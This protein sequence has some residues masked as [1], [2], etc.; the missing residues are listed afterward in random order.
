MLTGT[1]LLAERLWWLSPKLV[2]NRLSLACVIVAFICG[3]TSAQVSFVQITDPHLYD[4]PPEANENKRALIACVMKIDKLIGTGADYKFAVVTGD[5]GIE[6]LVKPLVDRKKL[7]NTNQEELKRIDRAITLKITGAALEVAN[8]IGQSRVKVWLF[9]PGNNDLIAEDP[10]TVN[11]YRDFVVLLGQALPG[12]EVID[13]C[14]TDDPN[15][16]VYTPD[17]RFVFIG[18]NNASFKN[19][20]KAKHIAN[21]TKAAIIVATTDLSNL[22]RLPITPRTDE[23]LNYVQQVIDRVDRSKTQPAYIFY[24]IP[25]IDDPHPVLNSDINL[26]NDREL[27]SSDQYA[28]SS[29]FVD[30]RVRERWSEVVAKPNVRGLFAGHFH[31][32]RRDTY[33]NFH[34]MVTAGYPGASL[35]KL[36]VCPPIS[37]KRQ[38]DQGNQARGFQAV[39]IDGTGRVSVNAFWYHDTSG[40]FESQNEK[41]L[42][43]DENWR[44]LGVI[45]YGWGSIPSYL[46]FYLVFI[47]CLYAA[48][49]GLKRT[50][51][52]APFHVPSG[53]QLPFGEHTVANSL[54]DALV[55]IHER[56]KDGQ[57]DETH[58]PSG[59]MTP[60]LEG[61]KFTA[62]DR[63][64]VPN[65][66]A[67]E[68]KGL[69]HD[70]IISFARKVFGKEL[71]IS[72]DVVGDAN[73][74]CLLARN[75]K[76]R[77]SSN[78]N[79]ATIEGLRKAC[80][81]LALRM[82][83][84]IDTTLLSAYATLR[85]SDL[86]ELDRLEEGLE[87]MKETATLLPTNALIAYDLGVTH[88]KRGENDNAIAAF[89][90]A[91]KLD[92]DFPEA[93]NNLGVALT[94]LGKYDEAIASY[95][96]ALSKR[97]DYAA[98]L[99]NLADA[100][101]EKK[102]FDEAIKNYQ[103][104]L[105]LEPKDPDILFNLGVAYHKNNQFPEAIES[106]NKALEFTPDDPEILHQLGM[107]LFKAEKRT[108][109]ISVVR[110]ALEMRPGDRKI[111][112]T[113]SEMLRA[114]RAQ[115]R[116][117]D[118]SNE[119]DEA[120]DSDLEE[121]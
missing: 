88:A 99:Y 49:K 74:F 117:R 6:K 38:G 116:N 85:A 19:D 22:K 59:V 43:P 40:T 5:I 9:L 119:S 15:S 2:L 84:T 102:R 55:K 42:A 90:K 39:S 26:L 63:F 3:A 65:R 83:G 16:G 70:A 82:L 51:V 8:I 92:N 12:K 87:L 86:I 53:N 109:A 100:L 112:K 97:P 32:W 47:V 18:F 48:I 13:L 31:D 36:Y 34:W 115:Q 61:M 79:P 96:K 73:G 27:T 44:I 68:V 62:A 101:L 78:A 52:I 58:S 10:K 23:Q 113:L 77:W 114:V 69:S 111:R 98:A 56:A 95:E 67:V 17:N 121:E 24:H 41:P 80:G 75:E 11:Y 108:D 50:T 71:V 1:R 72:G 107:S 66:F 120:G 89:N 81:V 76:C 103:K 29:W 28:L 64:E 57:K 45:R 91:V 106:Y 33:Q 37:I 54:R 21:G 104:A 30:G 35:T 105:K 118:G 46:P 94:E 110:Q 60:K 4:D 7:P 93:L 20:N 14:P 25:E